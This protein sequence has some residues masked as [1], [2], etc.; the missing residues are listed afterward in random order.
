MSPRGYLAMSEDIF[1]G[2]SSEEECVAMVPLDVAGEARDAAKLPRTHRTASSH[3]LATP[4]KQSS[5][6]K[7]R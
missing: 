4:S 7:C 2:L 1:G 6:L 5:H 3:S